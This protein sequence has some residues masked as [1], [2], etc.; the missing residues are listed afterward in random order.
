MEAIILYSCDLQQTKA[1]QR[2][3]GVFT[4]ALKLRKAV[5]TLINKDVAEIE[6]GMPQN[7]R[8]L[9]FSIKEIQNAVNYITLEIVDI[10]KL[11]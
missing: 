2:V 5:Q 3:E 8:F 10:N 1:S 7:P 6:S 9:P 11:Q 4:N